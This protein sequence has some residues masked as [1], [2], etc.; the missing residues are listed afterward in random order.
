MREVQIEGSANLYRSASPTCV[1]SSNTNA[2]CSSFFFGFKHPLSCPPLLRPLLIPGFIA[3]MRALTPDAAHPRLYL[4]PGGSV[5]AHQ[6]STIHVHGLPTIPSTTTRDPHSRLI[7]QLSPP[8]A[9]VTARILKG[10]RL[11]LAVFSSF[12]LRHEW[13]S[14]PIAQRR[15]GSGLSTLRTG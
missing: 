14:S 8:W 15:I 2:G 1:V 3:T 12:G 9:T 11:S 4:G 6:V 13:A 10:Y 7:T 5:D